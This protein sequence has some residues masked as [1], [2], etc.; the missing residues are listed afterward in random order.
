MANKKAQTATELAI[1]GSILLFVIGMIVRQGLS[2][3]YLQNMNLKATRL[4]MKQS[5]QFSA[6]DAPTLTSERMASRNSAS[7]L[8]IEDRLSTSNA[9]Y[10][11]V[12]RAPQIA[13]GQATHSRNLFYPVDWGE[14]E[15]LPV[16][17]MFVN[18]KHI[19]LTIGAFETYTVS[20]GQ[21]YKKTP[22]HEAFD[23]KVND[24][25]RFNLDR[26]ITA[27]S[28]K[29]DLTGSV[30][31]FFDIEENRE[32]FSWQWEPVSVGNLSEGSL[33][34]VD[35][36]LKEERVKSVSGNRVNVID[37]QA[38]DLDLTLN[39][40][41]FEVLNTFQPG[42]SN[43]VEMYTFTER[44]GDPRSEGTF[45]RIEEGRLYDDETQQVVR[46]VTRKDQIDLVSRTINLSNPNRE[47]WC[48][49][50]GRPPTLVSGVRNPVEACGDCFSA[51]NRSRTCYDDPSMDSTLNNA[52]IRVR[53]RLSDR[54]G[55]KWITNIMGDDYINLSPAVR[56]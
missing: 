5:F 48:G 1:F 29:C 20:G 25:E 30:D 34:D 38:G 3:G 14:D 33:A 21:A 22:N 36:D 46:S 23:Y 26:D 8:I 51:I 6:T 2:S 50:G 28:T 11:A 41:D 42:L 15:N 44:P 55:R 24:I 40:Y 17:D 43:D 53:S 16:M 13:S 37:S 12:D 7:V 52:V 31:S 9:K 32:N 10:G 39:T 47:R 4:A 35:C 19:P 27:G 54:R 18:G 56:E 45:L 49:A